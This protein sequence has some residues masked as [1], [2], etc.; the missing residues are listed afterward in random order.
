MYINHKGNRVVDALKQA[1][2]NNALKRQGSYDGYI[3]LT[4]AMRDV[5]APEKPY[6]VME[7]ILNTADV[8]TGDVARSSPRAVMYAGRLHE[9]YGVMQLVDAF[10]QLSDIDAELW[11]FGEGTAV[12]AIRQRA[13]RNPRIRYF[14]RV[15][16]EEILRYEQQAT[17]LVNPRSVKDA[18]TQYS[19]PSKTIEYMA[20]GTPLLTTRLGGIPQE[21][22]DHAF[23]ADDNESTMLADAMKEALSLSDEALNQ[24]GDKAR[25]FVTEQKHAAAQGARVYHF[26]SNLIG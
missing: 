26:L 14:G 8:A 22:F 12:E 1:Y 10:E 2:L 16:R 18:F 20:S 13:V 3:Y 17:L 19:F 23:V 4:E 24:K 25:R 11:L 15:S 7:G 21:Y 9:K 5:V 6:I